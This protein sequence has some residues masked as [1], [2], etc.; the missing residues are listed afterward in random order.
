[1]SNAERPPWT[2]L[3]NRLFG[4]N[5]RDAQD[6]DALD[7]GVL[8]RESRQRCRARNVTQAKLVGR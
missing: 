1:M 6:E 2:T 3:T 8:E 5:F 7:I 4:V